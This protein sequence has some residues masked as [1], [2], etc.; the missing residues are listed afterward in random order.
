MIIVSA[1]QSEKL[2]K[3]NK[4]NK[5]KRVSNI[6]FKMIHNIVRNCQMKKDL[7]SSIFNSLEYLKCYSILSVFMAMHFTI[8]NHI[9]SP[10]FQQQITYFPFDH[11]PIFSRKIN[12]LFALTHHHKLTSIDV[13]MALAP[14]PTRTAREGQQRSL[15][16]S[17][18]IRTSESTLK[19]ISTDQRTMIS[20]WVQSLDK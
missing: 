17:Q 5:V 9:F 10:F 2:S 18:M 20:I 15:E 19:T 16:W 11:F 13:I 7:Q 14:P 1:T 6:F 3:A 4:T 8:F 12:N